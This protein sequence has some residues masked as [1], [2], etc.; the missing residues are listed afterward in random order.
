MRGESGLPTG[1][2]VGDYEV[3]EPIAEG[4]FGSVYRV[5]HVASKTPAALKVLHPELAQNAVAVQRFEREVE[6]VRSLRHPN[7]VEIFASGRLEDGCPYFVMELLIGVPLDTHISNNRRLPPDEI[8]AILEPLCSALSFA[9]EQGVIHRDI[10]ASNVFL[11]A[12]D[13]KRRVVLLDF[14]VAKLLDQTGP[15]LTASL[16]VVGTPSCMAPEQIRGQ[17]A[18][19]RTDIYALGTLAYYMLTGEL[20]FHEADIVLLQLMHLNH[21]PR[22]PSAVAPVGTALDGVILKAL[23]KE[24]VDRQQSVNDFISELRVVVP[25]GTIDPSKQYEHRMFGVYVQ[26]SAD[27][28]AMEDGDDDLYNDLEK[29]LPHARRFLMQKGFMPAVM[30]GNTMMLVRELPADAEKEVAARREA[31]RTTLQLERQLGLRPTFDERVQIAFCI[32]VGAVQTAAGKI[33]DGELLKTANWVP[34]ATW[35][36]VIGTR[37]VFAG[38]GMTTRDVS[39]IPG[40]LRSTG[41]LIS[42]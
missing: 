37:A 31:V 32:H 24:P 5:E 1:F 17:P 33:V 40:Y 29:C 3:K 14:G 2:R 38:V 16:T 13:G 41:E 21:E 25:G 34:N 35:T 11:T 22:K 36:G 28:D 6:V 19:A 12:R 4:G 26:V 39:G 20:P 30:T 27:P 42:R 10:K 18:D 7:M 9:H 15:G 23:I 8:L